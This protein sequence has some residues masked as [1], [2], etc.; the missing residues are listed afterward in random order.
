[1]KCSDCKYWHRHG[2]QT[3]GDC[4]KIVTSFAH[5]DFMKSIFHYQC[6]FWS[7]IVEGETDNSYVTTQQDFGCIHYDESP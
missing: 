4:D 3:L 1:M 7:D 5:P 2:E 6:N